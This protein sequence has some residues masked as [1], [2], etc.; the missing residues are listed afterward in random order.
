MTRNRSGQ[1]GMVLI[2]AL[3]MLVV[4]TMLV[5]AGINMTNINTKIAYNMQIRNEAE[6]ATQRVIENMVSD[7]AN[8]NSPLPPAATVPVDINNDGTA[9][10][11][12]SAPTPSCIA[13]TPIKQNQLDASNPSDIPCFGTSSLQNTGIV[14]GKA[15]AGASLCAATTWDVSATYADPSGTGL[16]VTTHQGVNVRVVAGTTC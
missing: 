4:V 15:A 11:T 1:A 7:P 10:Y 12:V 14:G 16:N 2:T 9:D 6:D 13:S 8:F 3:I 5:V